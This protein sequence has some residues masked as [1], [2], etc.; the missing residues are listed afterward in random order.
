MESAS[1]LYVRHDLF[2]Q[3]AACLGLNRVLRIAYISDEAP[4]GNVA[5]LQ[6]AAV[7]D[8]REAYHLESK[9]PLVP[10][11]GVLGRV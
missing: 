11:E 7:G 6:E 8:M 10:A 9:G 5:A 3:L 4:R 2:A 1:N